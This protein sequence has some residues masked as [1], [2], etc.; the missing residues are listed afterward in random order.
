[1]VTKKKKIEELDRLIKK[2]PQHKF[3]K[4]IKENYEKG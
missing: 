1:M 3:L 2:Y 4:R